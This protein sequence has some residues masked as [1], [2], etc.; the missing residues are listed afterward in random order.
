MTTDKQLCAKCGKP[1]IGAVH[2][3]RDKHIPRDPEEARFG[4]RICCSHC[5]ECANLDDRISVIRCRY[6]ERKFD[7]A[8]GKEE[9]WNN[10]CGD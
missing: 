1:L 10:R 6:P 4:N 5:N 3:R 9:T 8:T 7:K 2:C